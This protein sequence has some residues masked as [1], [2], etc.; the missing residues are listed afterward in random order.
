MNKCGYVG[1]ACG[2]SSTGGPSPVQ[3]NSLEEVRLV[4]EKNKV[5]SK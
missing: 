2:D 3:I 1:Y 5:C 4:Y